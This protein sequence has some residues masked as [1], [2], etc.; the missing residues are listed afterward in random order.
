VVPSA[1]KHS[2]GWHLSAKGRE[3]VVQD[4]V[5]NLAD[6]FGHLPAPQEGGTQN[7]LL[8]ANVVRKKVESRAGHARHLGLM[9]L[10]TLIEWDYDQIS[11]LVS[12]L[13]SG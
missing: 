6:S 4:D 1:P 5:R 7:Y 2:G 10:A 11:T 3:V 8:T 13:N 9:A 12:R